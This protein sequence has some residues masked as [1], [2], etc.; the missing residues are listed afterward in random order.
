MTKNIFKAIRQSLP[1]KLGLWIVLFATIIFI[2][3]LGFMF[4]QSL[5]SVRQEAISNAT[6]IL[7]NTVLRVDAVLDRVEVA[8]DN[9]DWL[10]LRR[11]DYPDSMFVF[12]RKVLLNNPEINGCSISFEPDY[13]KEK[14]FYFSAYSL[15][16]D[17]TILTTQEGSPDYEYFYMDWYQTVKLLDRPGWTEPFMDYSEDDVF[18]TDMIVSYCKPLKDNDGRFVGTLSVDLSL[19]LLSNTISAVKP[20]P[21]SYSI[22]IGD[23]GTYFV[24]PD[25]TKLFYQTIFTPTLEQPDPDLTALGRAMQ[26]GEEGMRQLMIDG[27]DCYVFYKPIDKT[28]LSVAIVCPES[29]I[30]GSFQR[31]RRTVMVIVVLGLLLMLIVFMRIV[32]QELKPLRKLVAQTDTIAKGNFD[33]TIPDDGREDEIGQLSHSFGDMQQSLINYIGEL[34]QTTAAKASIESELRV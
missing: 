3:S 5:G 9:T 14:G 30:F 23:S 19:E 29:D 1:M 7:E 31:L 17:G 18:S 4:T 8:A 12:S 32:G 6:Q 28:G 16:D 20:Y 26:R 10:V 21:N 24:H 33:Q 34:R 22:M 15:N 27:V 2:A 13:F 25:S 11:L